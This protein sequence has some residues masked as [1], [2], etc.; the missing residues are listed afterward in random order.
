MTV[1]DTDLAPPAWP[2]QWVTLSGRTLLRAAREGELIFGLIIP[3]VFFTCF[4]VPLRRAMESTGENYAQYLLPVVVLQSMLFVAMS[5]ADRAADES[6]GGM[7]NRLRAMPVAALV[8]LAAR[9][10]TNLARAALSIIGAVGIGSIFGF[11]FGGSIG[12]I[13]GFVGLALLFALAMSLCGDAVGSIASSRESAGTTLLIP[14]M[15]LTMISTGIVPEAGFPEWAQPFARN[16]PI[17]QIADALRGLAT[18]NADG[19]VIAI[20]LTWIV[21]LGVGFAT[22]ALFFERRER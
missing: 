8:P 16:Q 9:A 2:R 10:T 17:S 6:L 18:G 19:T 12:D 5:A 21:A 13:A 14:Q 4:Y 11:R 1:P 22:L 20:A 3:V 7:G 15:L